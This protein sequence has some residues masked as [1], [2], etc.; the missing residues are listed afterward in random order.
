MLYDV[1]ITS[2]CQGH[3]VRALSPQ[4]RKSG[5]PA[6]NEYLCGEENRRTIISNKPCHQSER[7]RI[8][9]D[10]WS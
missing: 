7:L 8:R 6:P 3:T 10:G 1:K 9:L 2:S 5:L 4:S